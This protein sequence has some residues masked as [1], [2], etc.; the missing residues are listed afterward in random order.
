MSFRIDV[1]ANRN[2]LKWSWRELIGRALWETLRRP[3]FAWTPRPLWAWRRSVLRLF[4]AQ[5]GRNVHIYSTVRIAVPWSLSIDDDAALGDRVVVYNLGFVQVGARA[6][7]SQMAHLCAGS[8]D[9]R[10]RDMPLVK[11]P[12]EIG[13]DAWICADAFVG[14]G[15]RVGCGAVLGARGVAMRDLD[16]ATVYAGNPARTIRARDFGHRT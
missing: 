8:H 3:L 12:I 10:R 14:P 16:A 2:A 13:E 7:I 4:G 15:V 1:S 6:T 9:Y 11:S 5:I